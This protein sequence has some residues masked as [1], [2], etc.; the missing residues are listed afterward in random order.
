VEAVDETMEQLSNAQR[1]AVEHGEGPLLLLAGAGTGK[2]RALGHRIAYLVERR[3][4]EP[5]QVMAVTFTRKAALEMAS[6][7]ATLLPEPHR[8]RQLRI[9]TFHALSG[10]LLRRS[11]GSAV[12]P[13]LIPENAQ[14]TLIR[15]LLQE[16][17]LSGA[18]WQPQEVLR[19]I[20]LAKGRLLSPEDLPPDND[21]RF[22]DVYRHYQR[23]LREHSLLD[24]DDLISLM[25]QRWQEAPELLA[26]HRGLFAHVLVDEFQDINEAQYCWLRLLTA[27]HRNLWV[28]GD[29]DQSI[30]AFRGSEVTIFQRFQ[31]DFPE[32]PVVK[33][34][35]NY[36]CSQHILHAATALIAHNNNPLTCRLWSTKHP[37][38]L[39]R[40]GRVADEGQEARFV[41]G[42]IERLLGG[43]SHFQLYRGRSS[44]APEEGEY[45]FC[46]FAVLYRTHAQSHALVEAFSRVGIPFQ[47]VG[48]KAPFASRATEAL[49][50]YLRLALNP[51]SSGDLRTVFNLPPRGLGQTAQQ[52]L[53][54]QLQKGVDPGEILPAASQNLELPARLR[55]GID[56]LWKVVV[57][58]RDLMANRPLPEVLKGALDH[59]GLAE[60]V[61]EGGTS[62]SESFE[63]LLLLAGT[64][65]EKPA[66]DTLSAFLQDLAQ[67]RAGDF[68]DPR[69]DAVALMTLHA[70]K[71]L[72]FPVV[73][74][75]GL[76]SE[77]LPLM[78]KDQG[79]KALEEERR[80]CYVA[81]TRASQLLVL[82]TARRR[83]L[84]GEVRRKEPSPFIREIPA[85]CVEDAAVSV[86]PGAKAGKKRQLTLF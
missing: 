72:E 21:G 7:L 50:S 10:W 36:R 20:S 34:E 61:R 56:R 35:E 13:E 83:F 3:Y 68:L 4:V 77:L 81:M 66:V 17:G 74:V 5:A 12:T 22:A 40:L 53:A 57:T 67:W 25:I 11:L 39:V 49:L 15:A 54:E 16:H 46:D 69:A 42:E 62:A 41:V 48:E 28:V 2:T 85:A 71:G 1:L 38:P 73:F 65:G 33:L 52:W 76:D 37:G 43:S 31:E 55:T 44:V 82:T 29:A 58:L 18:H 26:S 70:A 14:V 86:P 63:W 51:A 32:A 64:H 24:F 80:L 78:H 60:K 9:G 30:Y 47:V 19:R 45:A 84:Y 23:R 75:C 79:T 27:A 6:R 59:T 8:A